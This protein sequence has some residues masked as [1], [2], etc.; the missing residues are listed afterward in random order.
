MCRCTY[1]GAC[2]FT[3]KE[4]ESVSRLVVSNSATSWT[5]ACQAPLSRVFSRQEYWSG[6]PCPPPRVYFW[7]HLLVII[8]NPLFLVT[9]FVLKSVLSGKYCYLDFLLV[10][11]CIDYHFSSPHFSL[12]L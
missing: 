3:M 11:I 1:F 2:I 12:Y 9:V 7:I 4:S 8:H 6:L 5:V 10:S